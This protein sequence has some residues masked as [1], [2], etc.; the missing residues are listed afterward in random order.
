MARRA[1]QLICYLLSLVTYIG[2]RGTSA[3]PATT[4][5]VTR[6][7]VAQPTISTT[8]LGVV[9]NQL[10]NNTRPSTT[11]LFTV[12]FTTI[13]RLLN[14]TGH[15]KN[16]TLRAAAATSDAKLSLPRNPSRVTGVYPQFVKDLKQKQSMAQTFLSPTIP[17]ANIVRPAASGAGLTTANH[18]RPQLSD[19]TLSNRSKI[20]VETHESTTE[21]VVT[22]P[23][24]LANDPLTRGKCSFYKT[25]EAE[26]AQICCSTY[27]IWFIHLFAGISVSFFGGAPQPHK[28][29]NRATSGHVAR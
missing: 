26:D 15:A 8:Q 17:H 6:L 19:I 20:I 21:A 13:N 25:K 9:A 3:Q 7:L 29:D 28:M 24:E 23:A 2:F 10:N 11:S 16:S 12:N 22:V 27:L 14:S 18:E 4:I 5:A 1:V